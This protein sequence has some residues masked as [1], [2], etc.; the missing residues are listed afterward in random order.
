M[1][2]RIE[3]LAHI[4]V[5]RGC[6]F[7]A[8]AILTLMLGLSGNMV[9]ALQ[10]GGILALVVC[11]MLLLKA[12]LAGL[13]SYKSTEVW[14]M[15]NPQDRPH[16]EIAQAVIGTALRDTCLRFALHAARVAAGLLL[17]AV[18]YALIVVG[19]P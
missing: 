11:G 1:L 16:S 12:W 13:R 18:L 15:L 10:T 5:A 14:L 4:S 2:Q 9:A 7:A 17:T 6:G 3:R 8:L 19:Q